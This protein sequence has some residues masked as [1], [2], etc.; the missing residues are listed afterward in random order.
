MTV[1]ATARTG[2]GSSTRSTAPTNTANVVATT[3][4]YTWLCGTAIRSPQRRSAFPQSTWFSAPIRHD[5]AG[6]AVCQATPHHQPQPQPARFGHR[7][8]GARLRGGAV[9][10]AGPR[11]WP[12]CSRGR[13]LPARRWHVPVG[14]RRADRRCAAAGLHVSRID[15]SPLVYNAPDAWLP[16]FLVCRK[17]FAEPILDALWAIAG[18]SAARPAGVERIGRAHMN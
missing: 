8:Q 1:D 17:E 5:V 18:G 14:F 6:T 11:Q 3:G 13:H 2:C 4:L 12:W 10:S 7:R 15:G 16:D 9:G